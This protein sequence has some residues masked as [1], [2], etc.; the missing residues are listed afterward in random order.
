MPGTTLRTSQ[1]ALLI[2]ALTFD[3]AGNGYVSDSTNGRIY[4]VTPNGDA[5]TIWSSG[6]FMGDPLLRPAAVVPPFGANGIEFQ[7]PGC[8]P[9]VLPCAL[10]VANTANRQILEILWL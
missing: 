8:T 6:G 7:P 9:G 2:S 10:Y 5:A 3:G 4:R 1:L